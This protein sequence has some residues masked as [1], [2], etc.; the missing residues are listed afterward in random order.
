[1]KAK[2]AKSIEIFDHF[3]ALLGD[4][5]ESI[6]VY[7]KPKIEGNINKRYTSSKIFNKYGSGARRI[8]ENVKLSEKI[9][10]SNFPITIGSVFI[11]AFL[12]PSTSTTSFITSLPMFDTKAITEKTIGAWFCEII[13]P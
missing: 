3:T 6:H 9:L 13:P 7:A 1:M 5:R 11:P 8:E 10:A 2:R 12:S 4:I